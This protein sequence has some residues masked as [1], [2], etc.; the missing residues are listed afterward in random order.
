MK[1]DIVRESW[2]LQRR[3][4]GRY[5]PK[6][7]TSRQVLADRRERGVVVVVV[8]ENL[9]MPRLGAL[10]EKYEIERE[11]GRGSQGVVYLARHRRLERRV[12]L[13]VLAPAHESDV[14]FLARLRREAKALSSLSHE[15]IVRL[16]DYDLDAVPPYLEL[17][18]VENGQS[19]EQLLRLDSSAQRRRLS[20]LVPTSGIR[21]MTT[22][23]D[24]RVILAQQIAAALAHVHEHGLLH[25]DLKPAN[26]LID[27]RNRVRVIDLGLARSVTEETNITQLGQTVGTFAYM[28]PEQML[29]EQPTERCDVYSFGLLLY[30]LMVERPMF[31]ANIP[32]GVSPFTRLRGETPSPPSCVPYHISK[33]IRRCVSMDP[34]AR[35]A[36]GMELVESLAEA[37]RANDGSKAGVFRM[38]DVPRP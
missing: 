32:H 33:L 19:L 27:S 28:A 2:L 10:E 35:P 38:P 37:A 9:T 22:P 12:A 18:Y 15:C 21:E 5:Y 7:L 16:L 4:R 24:S 29:A 17:E 11:L 1:F 20:S 26:V 23:T 6:T 3:L 34:A 36:N 8:V 14:R 13:K 31:G 30:E 25:R